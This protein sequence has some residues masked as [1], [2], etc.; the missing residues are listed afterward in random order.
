VG[1]VAA[2]QESDVIKIKNEWCKG[3]GLCVGFCPK[4]VLSL[5]AYGKAV[6]EH[7]EKCTQCG[8][9]ELYCPDFAI[10]MWR[11]EHA[12]KKNPTTAR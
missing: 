3:C 5:N 9:C 8:N 10:S 4:G 1:T 7:P 11:P 6:I 12:T 2:R